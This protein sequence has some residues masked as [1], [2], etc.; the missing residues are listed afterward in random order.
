MNASLVLAYSK[1]NVLLSLVGHVT[2]WVNVGSVEPR[3]VWLKSPK[4]INKAWECCVCS[5]LTTEW[6]A[7]Q[8]ASA[9]AKGGTEATI[10]I[11]C[12]SLKR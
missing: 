1:S 12:N 2:Y 10:A 7:S 5:L 8:V 3:E 9:L 4:M 11:T 6:R